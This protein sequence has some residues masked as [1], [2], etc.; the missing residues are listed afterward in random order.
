MMLGG[1]GTPSPLPEIALQVVAAILIGTWLL[2]IGEARVPPLA[3]M[4]AALILVIPVLQLVPLPPVVWHA[5][6]GRGLERASLALTDLADTWR[7]WS[8][9]PARTRSALLALVPPVFALMATASLD[10]RG[11]LWAVAAIALCALLSLVV[12]ALQVSGGDGNSFRFYSSASVYLRGFQANHNSAADVLLIGMVAAAAAARDWFELRS[13]RIRETALVTGVAAVSLLLALGVILT[14]SRAGI[15]LLPVAFASVVA[16]VW[17]WLRFSGRQGLWTGGAAVLSIAVVGL[18]VLR[19]PAIGQALGR[20]G[21]SQEFRPELWIDAVFAMQQY[22]PAGAGLGAFIP[23]ML[24][25]ERLEVVNPAIPNRA[26]NDF[27][28]LAIETGVVGPLVLAAIA[29]VLVVCAVRALRRPPAHSISQVLFAVA[30][31]SIFA[32]HSSVDYPLRSMALATVAGVAAGLLVPPHL[33]RRDE[34]GTRS[35]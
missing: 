22:W 24:A 17:P 21:F 2:T 12:G 18:V 29:V 16:I 4:L 28:E 25:G 26:H 35:E 27:L 14:E 8:V 11:R 1:G 9:S 6:P 3:W 31:F 7:P 34:P 10:R 33:S 23:V 15:V 5:L 32:L 30:A 13:S 19:S 20:F